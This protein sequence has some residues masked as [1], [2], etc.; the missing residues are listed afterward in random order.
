MGTGSAEPACKVELFLPQ[1]SRLASS[2]DGPA[3]DADQTIN[4][5]RSGS[6]SKKSSR[7][8]VPVVV[9]DNS[10]LFRAGLVSI[11]AGSRF[12]VR[13]VC[14]ALEELSEG[15]FNGGRCL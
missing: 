14:S 4:G 10:P 13:A 12:H 9:I 3:G 6:R 1:S 15:V 8:L 5:A 11:L 2:A 7:R